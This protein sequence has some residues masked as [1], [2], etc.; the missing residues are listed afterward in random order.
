VWD[1][2]LSQHRQQQH[3]HT[4]YRYRQ[5]SS[6]SIIITPLPHTHTHTHTQYQTHT[7][8]III[9]CPPHTHTH[10]R[11]VSVASASVTLAEMLLRALSCWAIIPRGS[12][13]RR[14]RICC[15]V[16]FDAVKGF[17]RSNNASVISVFGGLKTENGWCAH[18]HLAGRDAG[19]IPQRWLSSLL[20]RPDAVMRLTFVLPSVNALW[21]HAP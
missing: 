2:A 5:W 9:A 19:S 7:H 8:N 15:W 18:A 12:I 10:R 16:G 20:G 6:S 13:P 14:W 11:G 17:W 3:T 1:E 21:T 4:Q